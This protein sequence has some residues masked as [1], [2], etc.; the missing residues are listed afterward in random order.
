ML[1]KKINTKEPLVYLVLVSYN[2]SKELKAFLESS[3]KLKYSNFEILIIDNASNLDELKKLSFLSSEYGFT[4]IK[5][6]KNLGF[7]A[8]VNSALRYSL[9]QGFTEYFFVLNPDTLLEDGSV[10]R[11]VSA[12]RKNPDISLWGSLVL[13]K[14]DNETRIW[15]F[16]G[17]VDFKNQTVDMVGYGEEINNFKSKNLKSFSSDFILADYIPGCA[18]FFS[19]NLLNDAG[20]LPEDFFLYFEETSWCMSLIKKKKKIALCPQSVVWHSFNNQ[21]TSEVF[22]TY[23]YNRSSYI[24]WFR[25]GDFISKVRLVLKLVF[26]T[27]PRSFKALRKTAVP[28][29]KEI[30]KAHILAITDFLLKKP[31]R[32]F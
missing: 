28:K 12:A 29:E 3:L 19:K 18:M 1:S 26:K 25:H 24:F 5:N 2:S 17:E 22:H 23:Y 27:L 9:K 30:F 13:E 16:G 8:A 20:F 10:S 6:S 7:A 4:L 21:K 15:S 32:L 31:A 11:L 14:I